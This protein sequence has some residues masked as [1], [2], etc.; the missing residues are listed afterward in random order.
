M[1]Q[2]VIDE[3]H[4]GLQKLY[5]VCLTRPTRPLAELEKH[6]SS[7]KAY[8]SGLERDG[9]LLAAGPL[10]REGARYDGNGLIVFR[11]KTRE[12]AQELADNDPFH[13]RGLRSYELLP[14]QVNEGSFQVRLLFSVGKFDLA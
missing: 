11:A 1:S 6:L 12:E 3:T 14:W 8:L 13:V 9:K 7:H 4:D 2:S 10:L 5:F